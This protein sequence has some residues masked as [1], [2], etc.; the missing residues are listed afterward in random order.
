MDNELLEAIQYVCFYNGHAE[1]LYELI[2]YIEN[3]NE[4]CINFPEHILTDDADTF[5]NVIWQFMV[6]M[7]GDYGSSPRWAWICLENKN[8][9]INFLKKVVDDEYVPFKII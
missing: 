6:V 3:N 4:N 5:I 8:K 2:E 9:A 1:K 7:Y